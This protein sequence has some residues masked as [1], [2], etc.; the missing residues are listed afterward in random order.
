MKGDGAMNGCAVGIASLCLICSG[1]PAYAQSA[2]VPQPRKI[3]DLGILVTEEQPESLWG[4]RMLS[5]MGFDRSNEFEVIEWKYADGAIS[6]SN[7]YFTLFNHGGPHVDAPNHVGLG[8]GLDTYDVEAF[9]GPLKVF[10]A[11]EYGPGRT[12]PADLFEARDIRPG[13]I[14]VMYTSYTP[15]QEDEYPEVISLT[16]EAAEHLA[17]IPVRAFGTNGLG[18]DSLNDQSPVSTDSALVQA[19]PI[20]HSFLSRNIPVFE[21]LVNVE[22]LLDEQNMY[23]VGVPLNIK[24]GD[25]MMVRPIVLI[26]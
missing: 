2:S 24:D 10:D 4:K 9:V 5:D 25:G 13:D 17:E 21:S 7:P 23:F 3:V 18:V 11:S 20:H 26:Y 19:A 12:V 15:P 14:V 6:G 1:I 22:T 16:R 8:G